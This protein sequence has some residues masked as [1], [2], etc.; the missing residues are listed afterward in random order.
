MLGNQSHWIALVAMD[1]LHTI[2]VYDPS[3]K[4]PVINIMP[5]KMIVH[6]PYLVH[7]VNW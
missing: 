5:L 7:P 6:W 1:D 4:R 3:G 2:T